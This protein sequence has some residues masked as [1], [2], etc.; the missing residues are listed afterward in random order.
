MCEFDGIGDMV[1]WWFGLGVVIVIM[2]GALFVCW[3]LLVAA[4]KMLE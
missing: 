1:G 3:W 4:L 2:G